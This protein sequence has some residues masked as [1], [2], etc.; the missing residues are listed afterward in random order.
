MLLFFFL[1]KITYFSWSAL[2]VW[3]FELKSVYFCDSI[4]AG[5]GS[6]AGCFSFYSSAVMPLSSLY[7]GIRGDQGSFAVGEVASL[8]PVI[9]QDLKVLFLRSH[10]V[11]LHIQKY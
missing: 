5:N 8:G 11:C 1:L 7:T 10:V 9:N 2:Q 6:K 3:D 4:Q